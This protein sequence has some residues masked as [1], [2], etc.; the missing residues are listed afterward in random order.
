MAK[1]KEDRHLE[2]TR[3]T[4]TEV[5]EW[6]QGGEPFVFIDTRNPK[7]WGEAATKIPGAIR[8]PADTTAQTLPAI[9]HDRI[10]ITYCTW[11]NEASSARVA[12]LLLEQSWKN[13]HPLYGGFDAWEEAGG[14][15]E[16]K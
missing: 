1:P 3:V 5:Q 14:E 8:V 16:P 9:P 2:A 13:V 11:P 10:I 6:M 7:A 15:V 12:Q 4:V